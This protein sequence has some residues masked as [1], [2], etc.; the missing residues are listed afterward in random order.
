MTQQVF[1]ALGIRC[2]YI[3]LDFFASQQNIKASKKSSDWK[4]KAV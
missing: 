2:E 1:Q 4:I 3:A